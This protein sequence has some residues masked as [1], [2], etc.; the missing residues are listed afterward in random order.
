VFHI[1]YNMETGNQLLKIHL[2]H[3]LADE[4]EYIDGSLVVDLSQKRF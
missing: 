3:L 4:N 1:L 2:V